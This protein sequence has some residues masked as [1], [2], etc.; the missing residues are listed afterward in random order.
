MICEIKWRDPAMKDLRSRAKQ[1]MDEILNE[2]I[3]SI[4][5]KPAVP[6]GNT[7]KKLHK[8]KSLWR[9]RFGDNWRLVYAYYPEKNLAQVVAID[10]RDKIYDRLNFFQDDETLSKYMPVLEAA[11]DPNAEAPEDWSTYS[12]DTIDDTPLTYIFTKPLLTEWEIPEQYHD[13]LCLCRTEGDLLDADVPEYYIDKIIDLMNPDRIEE[14]IQQ[15]IREVSSEDELREFV[16]GKRS[17][18]DFLL[19][20]DSDQEQLVDWGRGGGPTLV[21]GAAGSGKSTIA[22][23]RARNLCVE[24]AQSLLPHRTLFTTY[25]NALVKSSDQLFSHLIGDNEETMDVTTVDKLAMSIVRSIEGA[26]SVTNDAQ[27]REAIKASKFNIKV[28]GTDEEKRMLQNQIIRL[29]DN[30]ILEEIAWVIEGRGIS[31]LDEY[32]KEDR[33]GRGI[34]FPEK[35]RGLIWQIFEN[36]QAYLANENFISWGMLRKRA[37]E[38]VKTGKWK[39]EKYNYVFIDE[40]QDLTPV[41]IQLC[42]EVCESPVGLF[43]TADAGQSIYNRGFSWNRVHE[44]LNVA[45]RTRILKRNYRTTREIGTAA[46]SILLNTDSS[47]E[48]VLHQFYVHSGPKP[49]LFE[50]S[51][52]NEMIFWLVKR[53][54]IALQKLRLPISSAAVLSRTNSQAEEIAGLLSAK[55]LQTEYMPGRSLDLNKECVKSLTIHSAKGLEFP[56]VAIPFAEEGNFPRERDYP[57]EEA[58]IELELQRRLFYVGCSR[59]MRRLFVAYREGLRSRFIDD[60]TYWQIDQLT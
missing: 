41:A 47:D 42:L 50:A 49:L 12:R 43:L 33:T 6:R 1:Y 23:Y 16:D 28:S 52:E 3:P 35:V 54:R 51:D 31:S 44:N 17:L 57:D 32:K 36:Y 48:E 19:Y 40:A 11:L 34:G 39:G 25:T 55:G 8:A 24:A 22:L 18:M 27:L 15:P 14:I 5:E 2:V 13:V 9:Y 29:S 53:I 58:V 30:Y 20:L 21:K 7:V 59:A 38:Y 60:L 10:H 46:N 4:R 45:G 26:I 37:L 56:I